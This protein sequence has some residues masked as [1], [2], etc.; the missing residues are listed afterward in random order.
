M[1]AV[2]RRSFLV[3]VGATVLGSF[4]LPCLGVEKGKQSIQLLLGP[5]RQNGILLWVEMID[6]QPEI[7][8]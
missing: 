1:Q 8:I 4:A 7:M 2:T 3:T 5:V 6:D